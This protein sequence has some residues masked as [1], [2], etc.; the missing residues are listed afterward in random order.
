MNSAPSRKS[1][2]IRIMIVDDHL[3]VRDGLNLLM[4]TFDD[5]EVVA[6]A[7]DGEQA[8]RFCEQTQPH[9]IL[10]DIVMPN[11]DG[12]AATARIRESW[13]DVKVLAL[14][15]Y[16]EEDLVRRAIGAG[17][18]GYLLKSASADELAEAIRA[19]HQGR[20]T[21]DLDA[22]QLLVQ[23]SQSPPS[24]GHDLTAREREVLALLANGLPN[25]EIAERLTLSPATVRVYVSRI[26][27]KLGAS[28]RT[29]A[30]RLALEPRLV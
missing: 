7:D 21:M 12:P 26:L 18:I 5:L 20:S 17:A 23:S 4:S 25:K 2:Q 19:A 9:V 30:A 28:N 11:V 29:E 1:N 10:M 22:L 15:S 3:L 8:V 6:V 14:T 24:L 13:P 16:V 27:S